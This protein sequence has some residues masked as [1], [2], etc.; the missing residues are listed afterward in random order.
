LSESDLSLSLDVAVED[1][2]EHKLAVSSG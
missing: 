1:I 2:S